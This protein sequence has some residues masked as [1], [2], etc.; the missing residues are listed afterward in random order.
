[1]C[2]K[3]DWMCSLDLTD[4]YHHV[5]FHESAV[6]Y[7][8]FAIET[9]G[10]SGETKVEYFSTPVLNFGWTNSPFYFTEVLKSVVTY[11]RCPDRTGRASR[12]G[13]R[14]LPWLDDF[15]FFFKADLTREQAQAE[16]DYVF[17]LFRR[18]GLAIAPD[19]GLAEAS[20]L[21]L[22][23]GRF[24][25]RSLYDDLAARRGWGGKVSLD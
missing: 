12:A 22:P 11:L 7:F 2:R 4:A 18:L 5:P 25:L 23:L 13:V 10:L 3:R 6:R 21:A 8:T 16:R 14:T 1:M 15:A 19:K 17:T 9:L 24:M 20:G